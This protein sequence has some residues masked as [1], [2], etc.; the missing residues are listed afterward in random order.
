MNSLWT[1]NIFIAILFDIVRLIFCLTEKTETNILFNLL[2]TGFFQDLFILNIFTLLVL[3]LNKLFRNKFKKIFLL[4]AIIFNNLLLLVYLANI[5]LYHIF[6]ININMRLLNFADELNDLSGS[7]RAIV[8]YY[9]IILAGILFILL[10]ALLYYSAKKISTQLNFSKKKLILY[11][12]ITILAGLISEGIK[13]PDYKKNRNFRR[14]ILISIIHD[15]LTDI[16][17]SGFKL[18]KKDI[19]FIQKFLD[20]GRDYYTTLYPFMYKQKEPKPLFKKK[21]YNIV[22]IF[23]ES[24]RAKNIGVMQSDIKGVTPFFDKLIKKGIFFTHFYS[25]GVQ[26]SKALSAALCGVLTYH[27][28]REIKY[29]PETRY[30]GIGNFLKSIGYKDGLFIHGNTLKYEKRDIFLP[31]IGFNHLFDIKDFPAQ[32]KR[33]SW[34]IHDEDMFLTAIKQ[35]DKLREPWYAG[36]LTLSNHHPYDLPDKRFY[37]YK[38]YGYMGRYLAGVHYTDYALSIFFKNIKKKPYFKNT[39][40]IIFGD[41]GESPLRDKQSTLLKKNLIE[42]N[43]RVPLLIY[44]PGLKIKPKKIT[45]IGSQIDIMPTICDLIGYYPQYTHWAGKSLLRKYKNRWA[46]AQ[47]AFGESRIAIMWKNYKLIYNFSTKRFKLFKVNTLKVEEQEIPL[48]SIAKT[49][50][51]YYKKVLLTLYKVNNSAILRNMI[52][53]ISIA[54]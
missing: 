38:E 51:S 11:F 54:K 17:L 19:K 3:G 24:F 15:T 5:P 33:F 31:H 43:I 36:I 16:K 20:T 18:T 25:C 4:T 8:P 28:K 9:I 39:I 53:D 7:I 50:L 32:A 44:A 49:E 46:F 21:K 13:L 2:T 47:N 14:N 26:T 45:E 23:A 37:K 12:T 30:Y 35:M 52:F 1:Y 41:H 48:N 34:G 22:I 42:D 10:S 40:F 29:F 6:Q 27:G